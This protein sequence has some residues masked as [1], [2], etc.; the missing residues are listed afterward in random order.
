MSEEARKHSFATKYPAALPPLRQFY[1]ASLLFRC[2]ARLQIDRSD[3]AKDDPLLFRELQGVCTLCPCKEECLGDLARR[4]E[5]AGW[6]KWSTYCP[7]AAT[8]MMIGALQSCGYAAQ[9]LR[10]PH[11]AMVSP[12]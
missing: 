6:D 3:L 1:D 2:M 9:H 4:F 5:D 8:L 12:P 7:N 10:K 11:S